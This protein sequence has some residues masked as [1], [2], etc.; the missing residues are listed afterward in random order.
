MVELKFY[1]MH[2]CVNIHT[3]TYICMHACECVCVFMCVS[4]CMCV[5][6][7]VSLYIYNLN[8]QR[9]AY[10]LPMNSK[11]SK[12]KCFVFKSQKS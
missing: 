11:V 5:Q 9:I 3:L 1:Y 6:L 7:Y 2:A 8:I 4:I 10:V 12:Q